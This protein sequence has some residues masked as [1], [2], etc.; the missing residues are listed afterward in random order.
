MSDDTPRPASE[1]TPRT[2]G[3]PPLLRVRGL[4]KQYPVRSGLLRRVT[5][6]VRAVDGVDLELRRGEVLGLVGESGCGKSTTARTILHLEPPTGGRV[7]FDGQPVGEHSA[8]ERR[9]FRRRAQLLFQEAEATFDP[10]HTLGRSLAEPLEVQGLDDPE[11][12]AAIV[13]DVLDRVRLD[14]SMVD[15]YPHECSGGQQQR[16][17]LARA[18]VL[19]PDLLVADEPVSGLDERVQAAIL[20]LLDELRAERDLAVLYVSHDLRTVRRF[21]DRVAVMYAGEI[22]ERGPVDAV[23]EAPQHPYTRALADAEP[24]LDPADRGGLATLEGEVPD[25]ADPPTGCRFHPRCPVVIPPSDLDVDQAAYRGVVRL[26]QQLEA[27][28]SELAAAPGPDGSTTDRDPRRADVRARH[29]I[30]AAFGDERA[31]AALAGALDRLVAGDSAGARRRLADAFAGPCERHHPTSL[32]TPSGEADCHRHDPAVA[33]H[34]G[35]DG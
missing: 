32:E 13:G 24:A 27:V 11:R 12:R 7:V 26:R 29:G 28:A 2:G 20:A 16:L 17:A 35:W 18:L 3:G 15:R 10:R 8:A 1:E 6:R 33:P 21:C 19:D 23:L 31:E 34:A 14:R 4:R 22:V 5:G 30:P 25:P 9:R